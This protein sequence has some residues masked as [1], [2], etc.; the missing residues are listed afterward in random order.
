M[1][2]HITPINDFLPHEESSTCKCN[3]VA[4]IENGDIFIIHNSYDGRELAE[5]LI[6]D[7]KKGNYT[8]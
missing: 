3:P 2:W 7:F 5:Q 8:K 4:K 6:E 1:I